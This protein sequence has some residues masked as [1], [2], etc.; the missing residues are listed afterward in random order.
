MTTK[1]QSITNKVTGE[2]IT[3]LETSKDTNGRYL[4]FD[5]EVGPKGF[6]PVKHFHPHQSETFEIYSGKLRV[7]V[8]G[9]TKV[10]GAGESNTVPKMQPHQWWNA[11]DTEPVKMKV[12]IEPALN[13]EVFFEQFFGLC[14]DGKTEKDGSPSFM[15]IMAMNNTY[16]I[17]MA[18]PP[19]IVQKIMGVVLGSIASLFGYKKYYPKYSE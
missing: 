13:T 12:K 2:K 19:L 1:H 17:Y 15:Q 3:W 9:Q 10:F 4:L 14:N 7:E 11:S 8:N 5:I 6:V 16:E 18:G